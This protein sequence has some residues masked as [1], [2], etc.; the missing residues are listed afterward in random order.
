MICNKCN[1]DFEEKDIQESHDVPKYLCKDKDEADKLGRHWLCK[2]CHDKY[3]M[4][5]VIKGIQIYTKYNKDMKNS[6]KIAS[7]IVKSYF[8]KKGEEED[9]TRTI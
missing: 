1:Q 4:E 7:N 2:D 9:D 8:F 3:D 5:I 6:F